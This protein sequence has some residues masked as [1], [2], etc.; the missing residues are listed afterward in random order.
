MQKRL[1]TWHSSR[2][3][4]YLMAAGVLV[5]LTNRLTWQT[6]L[7]GGHMGRWGSGISMGGFHG[8]PLAAMMLIQLTTDSIAQL[9]LGGLLAF[10]LLMEPL[11]GR[12]PAWLVAAT[13]L[14][15]LVFQKLEP[16]LD[17][18]NIPVAG[19][20]IFALGERYGTRSAGI[21]AAG[22]TV[23]VSA[24]IGYYVLPLVLVFWLGRASRA[25]QLRRFHLRAQTDRQAIA[26]EVHDLLSHTLTAL[27]IQLD[28]ADALLDAGADITRARTAIGAARRLAAE[29]LEETRRAIVELRGDGRPLPET[30]AELVAEFNAANVTSTFEVFGDPLPVAPATHLA[31]AR[32]AREALTNVRKHS[33]ADHVDVRLTYRTSEVELSIR[34]NGSTAAATDGGLGYGLAGLRERAELIGGILETGIVEG[35]FTVNIRAPRTP[36]Q[37]D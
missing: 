6:L 7:A 5:L 27:T 34:D 19:I 20:V 37:P 21:V 24:L 2:R 31:L 22:Y 30:V 33:S 14:W 10:A 9:L 16:G 17:F 25:N 3:L 13:G 28:A 18:Y 29:G 11:P 32:V 4:A 23:A 15:V 35:G 26:R 36:R 12:P 8:I 1:A